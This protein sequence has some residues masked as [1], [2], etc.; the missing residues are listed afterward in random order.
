MQELETF[1]SDAGYSKVP[2]KLMTLGN[3]VY[4]TVDGLDEALVQL[5]DLIPKRSQ[6][7]SDPG[8]LTLDQWE[9]FMPALIGNW[10][11]PILT[12]VAERHD[13]GQL[14]VI[15]SARYNY[16]MV[17][18]TLG[19]GMLIGE[20]HGVRAGNVSYTRP[21]LLRDGRITANSVSDIMSAEA[22]DALVFHNP[23]E[24]VHH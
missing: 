21:F 13:P 7:V 22:R 9:K 12:A 10:Q 24:Y 8:T 19:G 4:I 17:I 23:P 18:E 6:E 2:A 16:A 1:L 14:I 5:S 11:E 15:T 20:A 3:G